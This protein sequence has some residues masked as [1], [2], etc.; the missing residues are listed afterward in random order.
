MKYHKDKSKTAW[1]DTS[2]RKWLNGTFMKSFSKEEKAL[3]VKTDIS[4]SEDYCFLLNASQV[5]K[6]LS[7][8]YRCKATKTAKAEGAYVNSD[9][10]TSSW[11]VRVDVAENRIGLE[12]PGNCIRQVEKTG[13]II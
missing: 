13:S 8:P 1:G 11:L 2:V 12:E 10:G 6:Y 7:Y 5:K 9:Y 4:D 3:I